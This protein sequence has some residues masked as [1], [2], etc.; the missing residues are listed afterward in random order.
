[1]W[2]SLLKPVFGLSVLGYFR[3]MA[4]FVEEDLLCRY[5]S[6][7]TENK[8]IWHKREMKT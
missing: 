3:N 6:E 2:K 5:Y 8:T 7:V 4:D 1:M